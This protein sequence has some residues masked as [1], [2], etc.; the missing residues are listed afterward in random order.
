VT[1]PNLITGL[2]LTASDVFFLTTGADD[3][4]AP[5][6]V[7][8]RVPRTG[9]APQTPQIVVTGGQAPRALLFNGTSLF[10]IDDEAASSS[11]VRLSDTDA[12]VVAAGLPRA[13]VYTTTPTTAIIAS[14]SI[15]NVTL[16]GVPNGE[17][18]APQ[19]LGTLPG[20][21]SP[22]KTVVDQN[23]IYLLV[24]ESLG[25]SLWRT[26]LVGGAP[27]N[28][29][30]APSGTPHDV[31]IAE[32]HAFVTWDHAPTGEIVSIP[33]SGGANQQLVTEI[34]GPLQLAIDGTDLFYTTSQGE[35]LRV[36]TTGGAPTSLGANLGTPTAIA[37]ADAVY[38]ATG[39][40][41]VRLGR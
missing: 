16:T 36:P 20:D 10:W 13:S 29:W 24:T 1:A 41:I 32:G 19:A 14:A 28:I 39:N 5:T 18:G 9:A 4:G 33:L 22:V 11:L 21:F 12:R 17:A 27:E 25:G 3:A 2:A 23:T 7:L 34:A 30:S 31:A 6:G 38:V 26:P 35:L 15:G 8:A 40:D 37:V